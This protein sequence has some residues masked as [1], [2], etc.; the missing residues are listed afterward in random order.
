MKKLILVVVSSFY[1]I[2]CGENTTGQN[3]H[4]PN[5]HDK[6]ASEKKNN[7]KN[8]QISPMTQCFFDKKVYQYS[9]RRV[10]HR[11]HWQILARVAK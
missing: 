6:N 7:P 3:R 11:L 1:I 10:F 9:L 4:D 8:N 5:H 2:C